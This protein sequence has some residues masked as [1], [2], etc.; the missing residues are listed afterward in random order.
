VSTEYDWLGR[1]TSTTDQRGVVHEFSYD[2][3]GRLSADTVTSLGTSGLVDDSVL[4]IGTT[5][6]DI[7]RVQSVTSYSDT[8]GTA[9]VNEVKYEYNGWGKVYREYQE[10]DGAVDANSL[11]VQYDYADGATDGVAKYV[12]LEQVTYPNGREVHYD[13][14][15]AGAI[16]DIM[17][18]LATIGDST[19]TLS[20]YKYL[21]LGTIVEENNAGAKLTYLNSS[22]NVTGLDRFGR[23]VDQIW[24]NSAD[25]VLDHY[26]YTYDRAGNRVSKANALNPD[27]DETY[28]YDALDRLT[29]WSLDGVIQKTWSL[30][31]LGNN[32]SAGTYNAANEETP[33][34]GSSGY[35]ATGNMTTL[36]SGKTAVYDAWNRLV[37]VDDSET[38]VER[39]EYDGTNRRIQIFSDF[40][41][42]TPDEVQYDYHSGQQVIES[43]VTTDGARNGGYQTIWSPRYI[44]APVLRDTL[45]TA[46]TGI[47]TAERGFY[48]ADA[49]YNVTGLAK[50]D[51]EAGKWQS[52]ERYSYTPYGV[53]TY[54][55]TDWSETTSSANANRTLYTGRTLDLLTGLYYYRARYFDAG[56]ERFVNRDPIGYQSDDFN[57]YRYVSNRPTYGLDPSGHQ[58]GPGD[59]TNPGPPAPGSCHNTDFL[60]DFLLGTGDKDRFYGPGTI[61][62]QEMQK[63]A[64][65][66]KMRNEF[67]EGGCKDVN[68]CYGTL[69]AFLDSPPWGSTTPCQVGGFCGTVHDNGDGT[70]T[71]TITNYAGTHS[72]FL[73]IPPDREASR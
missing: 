25:E 56:L 38:V 11:F 41:G 14:G 61:Q 15:T 51:S 17:S 64:G 3:A 47:V 63:D 34:S 7:G 12:R 65:A 40:D 1:T 48:L 71:F 36:Q 62:N 9:P 29:E 35:D 19:G 44:D 18:R 24:K 31:S 67:Y 27:L 60:I 66:A 28:V 52:V 20:A 2:F 37:E 69:D 16:D 54:R 46:G 23:V 10:H 57:L 50:Y 55:N 73:H 33:T 70:A 4:A 5:Y 26:T 21:G 59:G 58:W 22:G 72:F 13:Y 39:H 32:L 49:N 8:S 6:D 43:D 45:N 53:V 68:V 42:S 30:D